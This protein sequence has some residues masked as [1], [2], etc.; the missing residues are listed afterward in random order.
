MNTNNLEIKIRE[1]TDSSKY[2]ISICTLAIVSVILA[3]ID[4]NSGLTGWEIGID[5]AIYCIFV[6]DY[7]IR[8]TVAS[9]KINFIK[10]NIFDL[11]A[12]IPF[13]SALRIFRTF[14]FA[15]ILRLSK[16][17]RVG[18]VSARLIAKAKK[19]LNTNGLKYVIL[20][21]LSAI[22]LATL[23][24]MYLEGMNF[25]DALWWSFVTTTTVGYGDLSP[26]SGAGRIVASVLMLV[27]IGLIGSLT[28]SITSYFMHENSE[29]HTV[30]SEKVKMVITLYEELNQE[31]KE[32]FKKKIN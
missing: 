14:K 27:G 24:M 31:E 2:N 6:I 7:L 29:E 25:E 20:L 22:I 8:F 9:K 4:F 26:T 10:N 12:V 16:L 23:G 28:S 13:S 32:L 11:I 30:S 21:S 5:L 1:I 3:I 15:K 18:S 17:M 19:F